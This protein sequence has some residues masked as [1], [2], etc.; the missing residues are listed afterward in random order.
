M[1]YSIYCN[2]SD[3]N[4]GDLKEVCSNGIDTSFAECIKYNDNISLVIRYLS[5]LWFFFISILGIF[6]NLMTLICIPFSARRKLYGLDKNFKVSTVFIL[7]VSFVDF[8]RC[9]LYSLPY[10]LSLLS[11]RWFLGTFWCNMCSYV[12]VL[13]Q[14]LELMGLNLI[15]F[16]RFLGLRMN[17][18]WLEWLDKGL[19]CVL[20]IIVLSLPSIILLS[21]NLE[22]F[23]TGWV[24]EVGACDTTFLKPSWDI[25]QTGFCV[26]CTLTMAISYFL[27]W[28]TASNSFNLVQCIGNANENL[29]QRNIRMTRTVLSLMLISIICHIALVLCR[30]IKTFWVDK[31]E[32]E[33]SVVNT[34]TYQIL[35]SVYEAQYGFNFLM[36]AFTN[37]QYRNGYLAFWKYITLQEMDGATD[38][39]SNARD[40]SGVRTFDTLKVP[41]NSRNVKKYNS[42]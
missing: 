21:P 15:G 20:L 9:L 17:S 10:G 40:L 37:K 39:M 24:C 22:I 35:I 5:G 19:N 30:L 34:I 28:R 13:S 16:T 1:N 25:I 36:Y 42:L 18:V 12:L 29:Y 32:Y 33:T 38:K 2:V 3:L 23:T 4:Y 26:C 7:F 27:I 8:W 14:Y 11:E 31:N 41:N 6:G